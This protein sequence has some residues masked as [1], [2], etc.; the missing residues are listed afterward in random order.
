MSSLS[1]SLSLSLTHTHTHISHISIYD[2]ILYAESNSP[3]TSIKGM[4]VSSCI[5][6]F[7]NM[8]L[9]V[10]L[11]SV[12][13]LSISLISSTSLWLYLLFA[14]TNLK[15]KH[16]CVTSLKENPNRHWKR[17]GVNTFQN[18]NNLTLQNLSDWIFNIRGKILINSNDNQAI[19]VFT[20]SNHTKFI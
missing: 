6:L 2:N 18:S 3:I 15:I 13:L 8:R 7:R 19:K 16:N 14:P 4:W 17:D 20:P 12:S 5:K 11:G 1:L 10:L 9:W